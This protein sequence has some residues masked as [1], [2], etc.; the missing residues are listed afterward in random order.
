LQI[1][2]PAAPTLTRR[3]DQGEITVGRDPD[4]DCLISD[5]A[6]SARH[7][8]LAY[9]HNQW[10]LEDLKSTNGTRLND[11][12]LTVATVIISGDKIGCGHTT[13]TVSLGE[14]NALT[15]TLPI[16]HP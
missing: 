1:E 14:A 10:W 3:F 7:A 4:C 15:P 11:E 12:R 9:H 2:S 8:R 16:E 5:E 13:L 6:A